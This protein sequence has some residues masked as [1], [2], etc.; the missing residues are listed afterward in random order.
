[1]TKTLEF[2]SIE[3]LEYEQD[4]KA[5]IILLKMVLELFETTLLS[6]VRPVVTPSPDLGIDGS[7][8]LLEWIKEHVDEISERRGKA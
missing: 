3:K 8:D 6:T 5:S 1:M 2:T 4:L 7:I